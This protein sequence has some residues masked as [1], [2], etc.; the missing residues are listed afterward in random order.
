MIHTQLRYPETPKQQEVDRECSWEHY[1]TNCQYNLKFFFKQTLNFPVFTKN[2][3]IES[4][5]KYKI[6]LIL[7]AFME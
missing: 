6:L 7:A 4:L 3:D 1:V 2:E 5:P